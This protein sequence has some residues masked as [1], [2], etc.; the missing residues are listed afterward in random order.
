MTATDGGTTGPAVALIIPIHNA[1]QYLHECL[2]SVV[3]Q[4]VFRDVQ[5]ILI[6]DGSTDGSG[7]IAAA[8]AEEHDNVT[9]VRQ[10]NQ[11][12][13]AARNR[14]LALVTAEFV[15]FCDSDDRLPPHA[16]ATLRT[17]I[18]EHD[19]DVAIGRMETFPDV[20]TWPWLRHLDEPSKVVPGIEFAPEL[21]HGAGPCGKLFRTVVL[22]ELGLSFAEGTHFE[23]VQFTLPAL[24]AA[25]RIA[26]TSTVI[27]HYRKLADGG[28]LM[29]LRWVRTAN[30]WEHLAVEEFLFEHRDRVP[31][32]R[33]PALDLFMVR[34][35]QGF[36]VRAPQVLEESEL[37]AFFD[38]AVAVY[39]HVSPDLLWT[40]CRDTRHRLAMVALNQRDRELFADP[41]SAIRGVEACDGRLYL[42]LDRDVP[43]LVR[44]LLVVSK[45]AAWLEAVERVDDGRLLRISGWLSINGLDLR[46]AVPCELSVRV[47]G[48]AVTERARNVLRQSP[49]GDPQPE[50]WSGFVCDIPAAG[51]RAGE[52]Q[53]RLVLDTPTGQASVHLRP[54]GG[55]GAEAPTFLLGPWSVTLRQTEDTSSLQVIPAAGSE[56]AV[57][58]HPGWRPRVGRLLRRSIR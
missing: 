6:D 42:Q 30:F 19:A 45:T 51:L 8:Y 44:S 13:G 32:P 33:R 37:R 1:A 2:D 25:D 21:I 39:G 26:L 48:S 12:A 49:A 43:D 9:A 53:L 40:G 58:E 55:V 54:S 27:Y 29:N 22:R 5:V 17:L 10:S 4:T 41:R 46:S 50:S 15:A 14:G 28:S 56:Q 3:A 57:G 35:F 52:H 31:G 11:G 18:E 20:S 24:L 38:R 47:R 7:D 16:I 23:D 36:A 34:S